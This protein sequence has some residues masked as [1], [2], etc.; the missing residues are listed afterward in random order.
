MPNKNFPL[1]PGDPRVFITDDG[2]HAASLY[3]FESP[4]T[5]EDL[6]YNVDQLAASGV[7]TLIYSA[8][9]EGGAAMYDSQVAPKW[10]DNVE[11]WTHS[12]WYRAS[13][14]IHQLI[15]DGH[16]PLQVLCDRCHEKGL[17]FI[18]ST[19]VNFQGG[20]RLNDGG[21]G[22]K[23][24]FVYEHPHFQVGEEDHPLAPHTEAKRFSFFH[25]EVREQRF[26]V[27]EEFLRRYPTDGIELDLAQFI[28]MCRF[29]QVDE[30][31]PVL[32]QWLA[33]LHQVAQAAEKDQGRRKR[34][35]VRIPSH[36]EAW[37][38]LGYEVPSWIAS[39]SIDGLIC[40]PGLMHNGL[41]QA[42]A[43]ETALDLARNTSCQVLI[44]ASNLV[45]R[46][47]QHYASA[48]MI[49]AAA[50][51]AYAMGADGFGLGDCHWTPNGWPWTSDEYHT[52]R[53]LG[54][55][56]LLATADKLYRARA[57]FNPARSS[58]WLPGDQLDLPRLLLEGQA[59][60]VPLHISD[61]VPHWHALG[62][63]ESI[64]LRIRITS[65]EP[66]LNPVRFRLNGQPLPPALLH[67]ND[68]GYRLINTGS[69]GPYGCIYEFHLTPE[70]FPAVGPNTVE[71]TLERHDPNITIDYNVY[72]VDCDIR[73]QL[74]R[75]Y[76][77]QP[78][79]Y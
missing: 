2:R 47:R 12:V 30:L 17:F 33:E 77:R 56:D 67:I 35:Y 51:N 21:L 48:P 54:Q 73:Y 66:A 19:W 37:K 7:D 44:A 36:P 58:N 22:R 25:P 11:Q 29:D 39:G 53:L 55:P 78:L 16:D 42:P 46:Q 23:T 28:P 75:N 45:G 6:A 79:N 63:I 40:L 76:R 10:G 3:Q 52:L 4:I 24:E 38:I 60:E 15:D 70:Y 65:I 18:A 34:I 26:L 71:I 64:H 20:D 62:R 8:V 31:A 32:T 57:E 61:D 1:P 41:S 13:R 27:F 72:D 69:V 14:N 74:H 5:P 68:L 9:L 43:I 59:V 50:A 49:W